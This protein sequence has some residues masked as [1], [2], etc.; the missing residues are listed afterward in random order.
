MWVCSVRRSTRKILIIHQGALGDFICCLPALACL[1]EAFPGVHLTIMGYRRVLELVDNRYYADAIVSVDSADMALLYQER[2]QDPPD[3]RAF[4]ETFELIGLIGL[5]RSPF[6]E[7]LRRISKE[8]VVVIPPF[9]SR[10]KSIHMVDHLMSLPRCLG[11][12][13]HA[14]VPR[15]YLLDRDRDVAAM[16]LKGHD[17]DPEAFLV[18]IHP[19]SGS[20]A[21]TW[22]VERFLDLAH[23]FVEAYGAE[24]FFVIGPAE[25]KIR[26]KLQQL[27]LGSK[28]PVVLDDLPLPHLGAILERCR[29]FVGNDSGISH[30]A[31][32]IGLPVVAIFGPTDPVRWAPVG[33]EVS[34]IRTALPCSPCERRTM[35]RCTLRRCLLGVSVD[36]VGRAVD[37]IIKKRDERPAFHR[38]CPSIPREKLGVIGALH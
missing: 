10:G 37:Q 27:T 24:V 6:V 22:P 32:A 13:I 18:G 36:E 28:R 35:S 3:L 4:F 16:F 1:R 17:I 2:Q 26:E 38:E 5:N 25:E 30:L 15:L 7:N 29:V 9:P 34:L 20:H 14:T 23:S 33:R 31:A 11:L 12:P 19:G 21:K 8:R